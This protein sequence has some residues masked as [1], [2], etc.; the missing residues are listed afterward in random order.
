MKRALAFFFLSVI[1]LNIAGYYLVFE[2]LKYHV[3]VTW[4]VDEDVPNSPEMIIQIPMRNSSEVQYRNWEKA[5]G[6]FDY[7]GETYRIVM[8]KYTQDAVYIAC[9]K[10]QNISRINQQLEDFAQTFT[11]KPVDAKQSV[12]SLTGFIKDYLPC[13]ISVRQSVVGWYSET[14]YNLEGQ[15]LIPTFSPSIVH[16]PE[17]I[18]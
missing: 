11:D 15:S 13:M 14:S 1:L 12:K 6:Q 16:P 17:R 10:D 2:G 8:Q 9:V 5:S 7:E 4:L 3:S 18:A